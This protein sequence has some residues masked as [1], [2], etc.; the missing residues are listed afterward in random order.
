VKLA[1]RIF[2]V[3]FTLLA[4]AS[5]VGTIAM[6]LAT[7]F[8]VQ[9]LLVWAEFLPTQWWITVGAALIAYRL[10]RDPLL[11]ATWKPKPFPEAHREA[12][13]RGPTRR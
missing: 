10:W 1:G 3:V 9:W 8:E 7:R 5:V 11:F 12:S 6:V 13:S 2:A 4:A